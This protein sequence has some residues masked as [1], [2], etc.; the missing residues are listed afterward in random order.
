MITVNEI[1]SR[2]VVGSAE[3][4]AIGVVSFLTLRQRQQHITQVNITSTDVHV[5]AAVTEGAINTTLPDLMDVVLHLSDIGP[6][7]ESRVCQV[8]VRL[9]PPRG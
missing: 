2:T 1:S 5:G 7:G 4:S 6:G 8:T 9:Q 3:C